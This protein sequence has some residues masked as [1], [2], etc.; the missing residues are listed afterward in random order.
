MIGQTI[1]FRRPF[2]HGAVL[3]LVAAAA[4]VAIAFATRQPNWAV[5]AILPAALSG[6]MFVAQPD[7]F[8]ATFTD[9]AV[10]LNSGQGLVPYLEIRRIWIA[11]RGGKAV[12]VIHDQGVLRIPGTTD[13]SAQQVYDFLTGMRPEQPYPEVHGAVHSYLQNQAEAFGADKVWAHA[14]RTPR[15][16]V[17]GN[18]GKAIVHAMIATMIAWVVAAA[19][20]QQ[21]GW[22]VAVVFLVLITLVVQLVR[23]AF[24]STA[25]GVKNWQESSLVISPAGLALAQG[26]LKGELRWREL[27]DVKLRGSSRKRIE[28]R[29]EGAQIYIMDF[30]E[31]PI[32]EIHQQ[33]VHYWNAG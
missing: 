20:L 3:W 5:F 30:Y 14:A 24:S 21:P 31:S 29:V 6:A 19:A 15:H 25:Q 4:C 28:L 7:E 18:Q 22:I 8:H 11:N 33:I 27:R 12:Y 2:P 17:E 32:S 16:E 13:A 9:Q 1:E 26:D 23:G 10:M